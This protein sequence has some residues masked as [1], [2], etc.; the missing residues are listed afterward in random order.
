[1][2][3]IGVHRAGRALGGLERHQVERA[4]RHRAAQRLMSWPPRLSAGS[5]GRMKNKRE[6]GEEE[7]RGHKCPYENTQPPCTSA[8]G[9]ESIP[10]VLHGVHV[11]VLEL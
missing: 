8:A 11:S 9:P 2:T 1:M 10:S 7:D 5:I 4:L 3:S 6:A